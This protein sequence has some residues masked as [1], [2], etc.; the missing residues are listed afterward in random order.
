MLMGN[1]V[2]GL[3]WSSTSSPQKTQFMDRWSRMLVFACLDFP[4]TLGPTENSHTAN[5]VYLRSKWI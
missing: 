2:V 4:Q 1:P 3:H 5:S